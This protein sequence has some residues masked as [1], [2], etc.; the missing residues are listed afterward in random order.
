MIEGSPFAELSVDILKLPDA[1]VFGNQYIVVVIDNFS[2]WVSLYA[3][4]NKTA[5]NA[6]RAILQTVGNFGVPL[7]IRSDGGKEFVNSTVSAL[8]A[9]MG[10]TLHTV[11]PYTPTANSIV[12]RVN[13]SILEK[14]RDMI[15]EKTL[16]KH[17]EAQ[18][19]DLLPMAQR[20]INGSF[21][22]S[23]GT[24]P[25][26]ILFGGSIDM[27]R[28][29]LSNMPKELKVD[30]STYQGAL[31]HNQRLLIEAAERHHEKVC[32]KVLAKADRNQKDKADKV[33]E[34]GQWIV[35]RPEAQRPIHKLAPRLLGPFCVIKVKNELISVI[36]NDR[37]VRHFLR[38][39]CEVFD[40]SQMSSV[41]GLQSVAEKDNF[42]YPVE[43]IW[44]HALI[45][46]EGF[47]AGDEV[48]LDSKHKRTSPKKCYQFLIKWYG[49]EEPTWQPYSHV[50][51]F[52]HFPNYVGQFPGLKM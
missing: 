2:H 31:V 7:R 39:N 12:E 45:G 6:A 47:G 42:E 41:E 26:S 32:G 28:C 13:R 3:C 19:T 18:W 20:I 49:H 50:R 21:H 36:T 1:D 24:S 52:V 11:L 43:A 14:L 35:V 38:R 37:R 15:F 46:D 16:V 9:L 48:Q 29:L 8:T 34:E 25:A 10:T 27:N 5:L 4:K 33:I 17:P 23:I 51:S 30:V 40:V 44:A 22:S